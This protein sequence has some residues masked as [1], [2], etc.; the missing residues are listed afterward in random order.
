MVCRSVQCA[1]DEKRRVLIGLPC[2]SQM[3]QKGT[4]ESQSVADCAVIVSFLQLHAPCLPHDAGRIPVRRK[5]LVRKY[6]PREAKAA[7]R[8]LVARP[9][10]LRTAREPLRFSGRVKL[11]SLPLIFGCGRPRFSDLP[12]GL[13]F[14]L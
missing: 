3:G 8:L 7:P 13:V 14:L 2:V 12:W 10:F 9:A 5:F 6:Q 1:C 4:K 11:Q